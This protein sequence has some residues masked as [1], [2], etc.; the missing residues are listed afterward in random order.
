M[1]GTAG[2]SPF[3]FRQ[4]GA[5]PRPVD[6]KAKVGLTIPFIGCVSLLTLNLWDLWNSRRRGFWA[7]GE[8][9]DSVSNGGPTGS[10]SFAVNNRSR[11]YSFN[12]LNEIT[13]CHRAIA[14][15]K[16]PGFVKEI[17]VVCFQIHFRSLADLR[18][19]PEESP[20]MIAVLPEFLQRL[21]PFLAL[22]KG[23]DGR[24]GGTFTEHDIPTE[25]PVQDAGEFFFQFFHQIRVLLV[26]TAEDLI[27]RDNPNAVPNA[28]GFVGHGRQGV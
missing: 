21:A 12:G 9:C 6:L 17:Q 23:L 15:F 19:L 25:C 4:E 22:R 7:I 18:R 2:F 27:E 1:S 8:P 11:I 26:R 13:F 10:D 24:R 3:R 5:Q 14:A 20:L 16:R 28:I